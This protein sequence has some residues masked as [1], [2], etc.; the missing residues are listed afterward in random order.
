MLPSY[1]RQLVLI[2]NN[3]TSEDLANIVV[4]KFHHPISVLRQG[5]S[6]VVHSLACRGG[7]DVTSNQYIASKRT[8]TLP[9]NL[10]T[11]HLER[12][13]LMVHVCI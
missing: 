4:H 7:Q 1:N 6:N 11:L 9:F 12:L 2:Q 5:P 13:V 10:N 8:W 3:G